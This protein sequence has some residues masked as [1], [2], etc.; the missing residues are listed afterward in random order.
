MNIFYSPQCLDYIPLASLEMPSR[1]KNCAEFLN[2]RN[3]EFSQPQPASLEDIL[4]GHSQRLVN[5][6]QKEAN[7]DITSAN[8]MT[9]FDYAALS[10]G[11][12]IMAAG[13]AWGKKT[14]TFSLMRPPG[15]HAGRD[16]NGGFCYFNNLAI[17]V[18]KYLSQ[19]G[20][21]A[22]LDLD[23][24]HGNG[25]QDIFLGQPNVLY[26]S[27]HQNSLF[28]GTGLSSELNCQNFVLPPLTGPD[29]Y[30][31][32]L[33]LAL[34][35]IYDFRPQ[36]LA[37]SLGLDT[38]K[39]ELLADIKLEKETYGQIGQKVAALKLP[40]FGVLEGGYNT[41]AMPECLFNF[42]SGLGV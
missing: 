2:A 14:K 25:T 8:S 1:V 26:V 18:K 7:D 29:T 19:A 21:I 6:V 3:F 13:L 35:Q 17:A 20:K 22:I 37:I 38:Y 10:A 9:M 39:E 40:T 31:E 23:C 4:A 32:T 24:H 11:S 42:L 41:F 27:L 28:P 34:R 33:D 30:L 12:A 36:L 16:F 5:E 15:H